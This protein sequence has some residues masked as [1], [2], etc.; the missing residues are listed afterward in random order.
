MFDKLESTRQRYEQLKDELYSPEVSSDVQKTIQISKELNELEEVYLL[1]VSWKQ[2]DSE[3]KEAKDII[4]NEKDQEMLDMAKEQYSSASKEKENIESKL[5]IALIPK[6]PNDDKNIYMEI[7]PAA[8]W[9][10]S[11]LFAEEMMRSYMWYAEAKWRKSSIEEIHEKDGA[12]IKFVMLKIVWDKVYSQ[13][14]YESWVH[15]V[16]R[17]PQ[18]ESQWRVH[19][20][21]ITVAVLPEIDEIVEYDLDMN[22]IEI[23]FYAASSAWWQHANRNK[24]WVRLHHWPSWTIVSVSD[25]RSQMQN[26]E[27]AFNVLKARLLQ[28]EQDKQAEQE[29]DKRLYQLW[30]WDR[31]EKIRTYNFPQDRVTDH[32]IKNS[33]SNLPWIMDWNI[34]A[35][36]NDLIVQDQSL[37]MQKNS[38]S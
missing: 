33:Y 22:D 9:D 5:E 8:G 1:Y 20:S 12:W 21:T 35:I 11:S 29:R 18:T 32:R 7:R 37:Q 19:T 38:I 16:Q 10:E 2:A 14:K 23:D 6:D 25:S 4:E 26:K 34:W 17:I 31:S 15:R 13:L 27:K 24:T 30:T 3:I 36:I 28:V